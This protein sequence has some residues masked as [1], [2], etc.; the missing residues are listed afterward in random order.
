MWI[1]RSIVIHIAT[2][3]SGNGSFNREHVWSTTLTKALFLGGASASGITVPLSKTKRPKRKNLP[4][5][6]ILH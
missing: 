3:A 4:T 6:E 1:L 2:T 5:R